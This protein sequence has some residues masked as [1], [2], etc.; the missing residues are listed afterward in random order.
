MSDIDYTSDD[1][2]DIRVFLDSVQYG[3]SWDSFSGGGKTANTV[4]IRVGGREIDIGGPASRDDTTIGIQMSDLNTGWYT[5]FDR[6]TNRG[7]LQI[8]VTILDAD[9]NPKVHWSFT[10]TLKGSTLPDFD[11]SNSSPGPAK[12]VI[13]G[14]MNEDLA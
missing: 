4:K 10:G 7:K 5:I 11:A 9:L 3:D 2:I 12:F 14:S 13:T 8:V 1:L 6:R